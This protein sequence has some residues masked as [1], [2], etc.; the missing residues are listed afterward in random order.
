MAK[1]R[2]TTA[3]D[4]ALS[5]PAD[6][7]VAVFHPPID[8]D[9][10]A[11]PTDRLRIVHSDSRAIDGWRDRGVDA[12]RDCE[13]AAMAVVVLPRAKRL[14]RALVAEAATCVSGGWVIVDGQKT[15][16]IDGLFRE[17]KARLG[18]LPSV[19]RGHGRCFW[20]AASG[21]FA[22][23]A[24]HGPSRGD[25]GFVTQ[26]GVFSEDEVD[27]G[28][29][30]LAAHLPKAL[31]GRIGDLGAGWGYLSAQ[32]HDHADITRID[33]VEADALA[34]ECARQNVPDARA[35][36]HWADATRFSPEEPWDTVI[37]NPPFHTGRAG[38][39]GIGVAFIEAAARGLRRSGSLWMV[40]NRHLPYEAALTERYAVVE[41][42]GDAPRFKVFHASRPRR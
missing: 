9:L 15:D 18:D 39:P 17:M 27:P 40:A 32:L 11:L 12:G 2:L 19:T 30:V 41:E 37:M 16:G 7:A 1:P 42:V 26:A 20:F 29:A 22:D 35:H 5:L 4:D 3:L 10:S 34:L 24:S 36:F 13:A 28:S 23:W 8:Y 33:L 31:P 38:D 25:H 21:A 6:G 14:A